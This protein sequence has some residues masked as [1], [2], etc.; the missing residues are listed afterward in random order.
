MGIYNLKQ[1]TQEQSF[2][3]TTQEQQQTTTS[4]AS[5]NTQSKPPKPPKQKNGRNWGPFGC[6]LMLGCFT[7]FLLVFFG[8]LF[9]M[10]VA[11]RCGDS[12]RSAVP[13]SAQKI[14]KINVKG[15]IMMNA[16]NNFYME[17]GSVAS[18][19]RICKRIYKAIE[20]D[21][22]SGI[23]L[24]MNTP[25]GEVVASDEIRKAVDA[26]RNAGKPVV[27]CIHTMGCSGGY[28]IASGSDWIVAN[29]LS[30][31]GS[32]GVILSSYQVSGLLDKL[33]V[34]PMVY[35][36]G[37]FKDILSSGR[38]STQEEDA[39]LQS[40]VAADFEYFCQV[41]SDGRQ[42]YFPTVESVRKAEFADGRPVSGEAALAYKLVDELGGFESAKDKMR[43]LIGDDTAD[44]VDYKYTDEWIY[45]L[46]GV[47]T[48]QPSLRIEG[49]PKLPASSTL[50]PAGLFYYLADF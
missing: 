37:K 50:A 47:V 42:E 23:I 6:G 19:E 27:T 14:A 17:N 46:F 49:M 28:Y 44:V 41:I 8:F 11:I 29:R 43:E 1:P 31:T 16:P 45:D 25:G 18:A 10:A 20:D 40:M 30:L 12:G 3:N 2:E 4:D 33:G 15:I 24:D 9:L 39:Y 22:I 7:P 13:T 32:I 35:R 21:S 38:P 36:S 26:C 5:A 34:K 48:Q